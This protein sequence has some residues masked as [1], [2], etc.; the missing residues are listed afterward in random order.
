MLTEEKFIEKLISLNI[1]YWNGGHR[2]NYMSPVIE[3]LKLINPSTALE[4]GPYKISLMS[5]SDE[6]DLYET[7][8][9]DSKNNKKLNM[10]ARELP[11]PFPDKSYDVVVGLQIFEHIN[12]LQKEVF[13]E[14]ERVAD[15]CILSLPYKW[16]DPGSPNHSGI[17]E[18]VIFNWTNKEP[19]KTTIAG[20][21]IIVCYKF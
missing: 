6:I 1:K 5:F 3:E 20:I 16:D 17:D 21:R 14:I 11:W 15:Y 13:K 10:D 8:F 7:N 2:W 12:P 4:L 19:Y 9:D 18:E